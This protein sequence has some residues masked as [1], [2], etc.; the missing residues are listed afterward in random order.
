[1]AWLRPA[2][3][4]EEGA[5]H[6]AALARRGMAVQH[7]N[8]PLVYPRLAPKISA[9]RWRIG[10]IICSLLPITSAVDQA[11][12]AMHRPDSR[13]QIIDNPMQPS[14]ATATD[15]TSFWTKAVPA[16]IDPGCAGMW[17]IVHTRSTL[18]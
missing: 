16:S 8:L 1:M 3:H 5:T 10:P 7:C 11:L 13:S 17:W 4:A 18:S 14:M 6:A 9:P 15:I 12:V 2:V